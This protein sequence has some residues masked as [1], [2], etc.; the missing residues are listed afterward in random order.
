MTTNSEFLQ[1]KWYLDY[2]E[3]QFEPD[4]GNTH[5][6]LFEM[7]NQKEFVWFVPNDDNRVMDG[8][9]IRA[10][11]LKYDGPA[12][13]LGPCSFLE[14]LI[15]VSRHIAFI[16]DEDTKAWARQL[17]I[18]LDL[19]RMRDPLSR[20]KAKKADAIMETV[21]WRTYEIN[22]EGGFFPLIKP[23]EDQRKVEIWFQMSAYIIE[24]HFRH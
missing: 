23:K 14:V 16:I 15:G 12:S 18:N 4:P 24:N 7:M 10:D 8:L 21:I 17:L 3:R 1:D 19:N 6:D 9:Q 2:L 20:Y 22:G 11:W 5:R 13:E